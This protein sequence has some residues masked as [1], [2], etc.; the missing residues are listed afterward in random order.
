MKMLTVMQR[1]GCDVFFKRNNIPATAGVPA[2]S[3]EIKT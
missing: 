1:I 2:I 3:G